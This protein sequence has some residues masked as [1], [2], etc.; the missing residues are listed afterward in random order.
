[1]LLKKLTSDERRRGVILMVVLAM[2]T[3]FAIIGVTF[4]LYSNAAETSAR[5]AK[6][7]EEISTPGMDPELAVSMFISQFLYDVPDSY[8]GIGSALRGHSL[9]RGMYGYNS[10]ATYPDDK[11]FTGVGKLHFASPYKGSPVAYAGDDAYLVNFQYFYNKAKPANSDTW[12]RDPEF[13]QPRKNGGGQTDPAQ[14]PTILSNTKFRGNGTNTYTGGWNVPYTYPDLQ[15]MFLAMVDSGGNVLMPS[16]H[17]PWLFDPTNKGYPANPNW[18]NAEGKHLTLVV[19]PADMGVGFPAPD[20]NGLSVKNLDW[21][22]G[23]NDSG[24]ID[25]G[26]PVITAPN[27][28]MYKMLA[29]PLIMEL[30]S[31]LNLNA[32]GNLLVGGNAHSS[33]QGWGPTEINIGAVLSANN[34]TPAVAITGTITGATNAGPISITSANHGLASGLTVTISAVGGNTA[35]NGTWTITSTGVNTF[36]LNGSDGSQSPAY[37]TGGTWTLYGGAVN[38]IYEWSNLFLG[39]PPAAFNVSGGGYARTEGRYGPNR[40]PVGIGVGAGTSAREWAPVDLNGIL[41]PFSSSKGTTWPWLLPGQ[42]QAPSFA[43]FPSFYPGGPPATSSAAAGYGNGVP[44]ETWL[45]GTGTAGP[46]NNDFQ[47]HPLIYDAQR[48]MFGNRL[49]PLNGQAELLRFGSTNA[50]ALTSDLLRLCPQN[51]IFGNNA[52]KHRLQVTL[53]SAALDRIHGTPYITDPTNANQEYQ[54]NPKL[55]AG[56]WSPLT[57]TQQPA[58]GYPAVPVTAGAVNAAGEFDPATYRSL[59]ADLRYR[60]DLN[61]QLTNYPTPDMTT[62]MFDVTNPTQPGSLSTINQAIQDRQRLAQDIFDALREAVGIQDPNTVYGTPAGIASAITTATPGASPLLPITVTLPGP[63]LNL[64]TGTTVIITGNGLANGTWVITNPGANPTTT[65]TLNGS[66]APAGATPVNG[67]NVVIETPQFFALRYLAQLAANIVDYIDYDDYSTP[68]LW[69]NSPAGTNGA[70]AYKEYVYGTELPRLVLNEIYGEYDNDAND[71]GTKGG[72]ANYYNA[73]FWVELMNPFILDKTQNGF[74][75]PDQNAILYAYYKNPGTGNVYG[76]ANYMVV[77]AGQN[78]AI[79]QQPLDATV[80]RNPANVTGDPDFPMVA[81]YTTPG[82]GVETWQPPVLTNIQQ[83]YS[84]AGTTLN[85]SAVGPAPTANAPSQPDYLPTIP[86]LVPSTDLTAGVAPAPVG[87]YPDYHTVTPNNNQYGVNAPTG[88]NVYNA[89]FYILGPDT[90]IGTTAP[91]NASYP[92]VPATTFR[93]EMK[94]QFTAGGLPNSAPGATVILRRL[95][96]P[97]LPP[98]DPASSNFN[99]GLPA[100]PYLTIDYVTVPPSQIYNNVKVFGTGTP[101]QLGNAS[102]SAQSYGRSQPYTAI[103]SQQIAQTPTTPIA[104]NAKSVPTPNFPVNTTFY[105]QNAIED[106]PP[107]APAQFKKPNT[108]KVPF[109]W[110]VHLDRQLISPMELLHVSGYKQHELTQQ[111]VQPGTGGFGTSF[112]H[113]APWTDQG[114]P[115]VYPNGQQAT[116]GSITGASNP[117]SPIE[118]TTSAAHGLQSG[119][120]VSIYG[121][122]GNTS[123]NGTWVITV[124]ANNKF[125]LTGS[126]GNANYTANTGTWSL[127]LQSRLY[128]FLELVETKSRAAGV[129]MGGRV[130]GKINI[131]MV[132]DQEIFNALCDPQIANFFNQNDVNTVFTNLKSQRSPG[133]QPGANDKPFWGFSIGTALGATGTSPADPLDPHSTLPAQF[134]SPTLRG[135]GNTLLR[136]GIQNALAFDPYA[137]D[138]LGTPVHPYKRLQL[139]NKIFNNLTTHSNVFAVWLTV[140]FFEVTNANTLPVQLGAEIGSAEG[141]QVRHRMFAIVDRSQML[142]FSTNGANNAANGRG[143]ITNVTTAGGQVQ[144]TSNNHNLVAGQMVTISGVQGYTTANGRWAVASVTPNTFNVAAPVGGPYTGGGIWV[145]DANLAAVS[146]TSPNGRTWTLPTAAGPPA[147]ALTFEPNANGLIANITLPTA[148]S[149]AIVTSF[150]HGLVTGQSVTIAGVTGTTQANSTFVIDVPAAPLGNYQFNLRGSQGQTWTAFS[151]GGS[152]AT[153]NEETVLV[154]YDPVLKV[155][156]ANFQNIHP[157]GVSVISRGNPGPWLTSSSVEHGYSVRNDTQVVPYFAIID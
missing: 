148:A 127:N 144:V 58:V 125:T 113:I 110:L 141:R 98:N 64:P 79:T 91:V 93:P 124:T 34:T 95:A 33:N 145:T 20:F 40:F 154:S 132:W 82:P 75:L 19:R 104:A 147:P 135:V 51:F 150:N 74:T 49:L 105:R 50:S 62:G 10:N 96:C 89:G 156:K 25:I 121:V 13:V 155:Y 88:N 66:G 146:G 54:L 42:G 99:A 107:V 116:S 28:Q 69:L 151:G 114:Y 71:P 119:Q 17:R 122:G 115:V 102:K 130:P 100:N 112:Q 44:S 140:G 131:N 128:R 36:T 14:D 108:M 149:N 83:Y 61:R 84:V 67:G 90:P 37:T 5:A 1:M 47:I 31:K 43:T 134:T 16:Y 97:G 139:L 77:L 72:K 9:V 111:F 76:W 118:I 101:T 7:A 133:G 55:N 57:P 52:L 123:A 86:P 136:P 85:Y 109:D 153:N 117:A 80:L 41:D 65:F 30:D 126:T 53:L 32:A 78:H 94:F 70:P 26:A 6:Q 2:L 60:V 56:V 8:G 15:N 103:A 59:V 11:P 142:A 87:A 23:G 120:I 45:Q 138:N 21:A 29:A 18:S 143:T 73:N 157:A 39:N 81:T 24:W 22:P 92:N 63:G 129:A 4:V 38:N 27:G 68:F 48:P 35:A 12:V 46:P 3:L 137:P 152:W 106:T